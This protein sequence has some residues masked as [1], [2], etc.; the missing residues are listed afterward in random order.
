M[1]RAQV[2][3]RTAR[4]ILTRT[5]GYLAGFTH[6]LQPYAGCQFSCS[7]CYVREMAVQRTNPH[8]LPWSKWIAP[9]LN[10]PALLEREVARG[11]LAAAR[12]F[13]S[14][15]T[16]PYTPLERRLRLTRGCLEVMQR[17]PPEALIVQTRSP[18]V[19][20][21]AGLI[22]ALPSAAVS[23]TITTSDEGVRRLFEPDSPSV[24]RRLE[25]LRALRA[26]GV[27]TQAAL[28]ALLPGDVSELAARL[29]PVVDRVV[30]DDF[31][32]GD[33]AGGAR[34]RAAL[35]VLETQGFAAWSQPGYAAEATAILR[36]TLGSERVV[37]SQAGFND[38][39][40]LREV[41]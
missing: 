23:L 29:A 40:W 41:G 31:F 25:T 7:Y 1:A 24:A 18:L 19:V 36:R 14:S 26:A 15:A 4:S 17:Q 32:R 3:P 21:D 39:S 12:I 6:T 16:D 35:K 22:A 11:R 2:F 28:A 38:V 20:R 8:R 33:G 13:C 9:K 34:S 5:G 30:V 37:E 27:R 10:A